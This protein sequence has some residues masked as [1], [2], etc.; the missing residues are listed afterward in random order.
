VIVEMVQI[1]SSKKLYNL[2]R[3]EVKKRIVAILLLE[4]L[5]IENKKV[6]LQPLEIY[7]QYNIDFA[8]CI[9][10]IKSQKA[11]FQG[12][13]SYDRDFDKIEGGVLE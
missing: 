3:E 2:P 9:L 6:Y 4:N 8:D 11:E 10:A 13:Y 5:K 7:I 12:I 1:L